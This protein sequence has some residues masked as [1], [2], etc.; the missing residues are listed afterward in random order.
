MLKER[1]DGQV[2]VGCGLVRAQKRP[3]PLLLCQQG[4]ARPPWYTLLLSSVLPLRE[5]K[6]KSHSVSLSS[7]DHIWWL[8][9]LPHGDV[10][11]SF[12]SLLILLRP[13]S[14]CL[15]CCLAVPSL[16]GI[17]HLL[18]CT[19][20]RKRVRGQRK[21]AVAQ[22]GDQAAHSQPDRQHSKSS[23]LLG[24]VWFLTKL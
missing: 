23:K 17:C 9:S 3:C 1:G 19:D 10:V 13:S 5:V 20:T 16:P 15:S 7:A 14:P 12:C 21:T 4:K 8:S 11:L 18:A 24:S 22:D 2:C 6:H